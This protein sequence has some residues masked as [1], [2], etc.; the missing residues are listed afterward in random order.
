MRPLTT[1]QPI[2]TPDESPADLLP[3]AKRAEVLNWILTHEKGPKDYVLTFYPNVDRYM[4]G[5][6]GRRISGWLH[7][8]R[9]DAGT[10]PIDRRRTLQLLGPPDDAPAP[11]PVPTVPDPSLP[12][13]AYLE[14]QA[15]YLSH[16][17]REKVDAFGWAGQIPKL[18]S[19]A[20]RV[21]E[22]LAKLREVEHAAE[23]AQ[24]LSPEER[25][26]ALEQKAAAMPLPELE[27][28]VRVYCGRVGAKVVGDD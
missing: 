26:A 24:R 21:N 6:L 3:V 14:A 11:P 10:R 15:A 28:F 7:K 22:E 5:R 18:L 13:P 12:R 4:Q 8:A 19:E 17:V 20:A 2:T 1:E 23:A 27:L 25:R 16:L 9:E